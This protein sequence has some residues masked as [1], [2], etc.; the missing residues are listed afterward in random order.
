MDEYQAP[1]G[2]VFDVP[3]PTVGEVL[4]RARTEKGLELVDIA[5][6]TRVPIR[7]L[8]AI[9]ADAHESLPALPYAIGFVKTFARHVGLDPAATSAQF[10]AE[11]TKG[12]HV[13]VVLAPLEPLDERRVPSRALIAACALGL[14]TV[15]AVVWAYGAGLI[16]VPEPEQQPAPVVAAAEPPPEPAPVVADS[17]AP[18]PTETV[19]PTVVDPNAS[20][21]ATEDAA[22]PPVSAD[23]PVTI[24]ASEDAWFKVYGDGG[25]VKMGILQSGESYTVPADPT[26]L[27]LWTG[28]AGALRLSVGGKPLP[29]IGAAK[30]TI[31]DVSLTPADLLSR[32]APQP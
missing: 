29:A 14:V 26:G 32:A 19:D 21:A 2:D 31:K 4:R 16:A 17:A 6:E 13:P 7:H 18:L 25:T 1:L 27:K 30:Q 28:N 11:T 10:K 15:I 22:A 9:E 12:V 24:T 3:Q 23:G 20:A 5:R 8:A